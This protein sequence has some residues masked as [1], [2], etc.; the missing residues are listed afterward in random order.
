MG[1]RYL[2]RMLARTVRD[3]ELGGVLSSLVDEQHEIEARVQTL[4][5]ERGASAPR[6]ARRRW[7]G[8]LGVWLAALPLGARIAVRLCVDAEE[9]VQRW[10]LRFAQYEHEL[11]RAASAERFAELATSKG[12]HASVLRT[13]VERGRGRRLSE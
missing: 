9:T 6:R 11:G 8:S 4:L 13:W 7:L 3:R 2:Y 12:R 10:Y 5:E 1:A